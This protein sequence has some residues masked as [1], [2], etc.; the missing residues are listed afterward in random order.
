V[1]HRA[2]EQVRRE[3]RPVLV[4]AVTYRF[5]GHS[6]ADPEQY[7][8]KEEVARWRER[9]PIPAFGRQLLAAGVL[10]ESALEQIDA[11][12]VQRV[13]A[14]VAFA[15]SSPF[16]EPDTLYDGVYVLEGTLSGTYSV[17]TTDP[18]AHPVPADERGAVPSDGADLIPKQMS[19]ALLL[20]EEA[21]T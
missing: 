12:A 1:L 9:D 20:G 15:E 19:D 13:D 8:T 4:E 2:V 21:G 14:A 3:R 10:D 18:E 7:R 6:M 17:M 16:P 11:E 5:R